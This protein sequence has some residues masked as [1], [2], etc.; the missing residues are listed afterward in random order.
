MEPTRLDV[1]IEPARGEDGA[2]ILRLLSVAGLPIDG[3]LDHLD[4]AVVA[5]AGGR[6]VGCAALEVYSDGALLQIGRRRCRSQ[7]ARARNAGHDCSTESRERPW[8]AGGVFA[9]D[10]RR[11]VLS[12]VRVRTHR[13][14]PG[15]GGRADV[16]GVPVR[17]PVD[18][19]RDEKSHEPGVSRMVRCQTGTFL[20]SRTGHAIRWSVPYRVDLSNRST[21][22]SIGSS[23]SARLTPS[24]RATAGSRP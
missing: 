21:M 22:R 19:N 16:G 9:H 3:L 7:R 23:N 17:M 1:S 11:G 5:R 8:H 24:N 15:A 12:E 13:P 14:R 20:R 10:Y 6:V 2:A 4:T 18:R